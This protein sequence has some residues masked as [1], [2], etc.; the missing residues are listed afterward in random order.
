VQ[1]RQTFGLNKSFNIGFSTYHGTVRAA[2]KWGRPGQ[3]MEINEARP[4]SYEHLFHTAAMQARGAEFKREKQKQQKMKDKTKAE[5][6]EEEEEE[7]EME[8][9]EKEMDFAVIL[10]SNAEEI[11]GT[12]SLSP[13]VLSPLPSPLS[14]F[15][16][17]QVWCSRSCDCLV[18]R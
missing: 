4:E 13:F 17:C 1:V 12:S 15:H 14:L 16:S 3:V 18:G 5:G 2:T 8:L 11:P 6:E 10:R 9:E 7:E